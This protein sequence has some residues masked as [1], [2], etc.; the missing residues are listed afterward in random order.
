MNPNAKRLRIQRA[1]ADADLAAAMA[2]GYPPAIAAAETYQQ[3][4]IGLQMAFAAEQRA[5]FVQAGFEREHS[6][7]RFQSTR[8]TSGIFE[9]E[10][11]SGNETL[12]MRPDPPHSPS[13]DYLPEETFTESQSQTYS[14]KLDLFQRLPSWLHSYAKDKQRWSVQKCAATLKNK[15]D[16]WKPVFKKVKP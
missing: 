7:A 4:V 12:A 10:S 8:G 6:R 16:N 3:M 15:E 14:Y 11:S 5:V 2:S 13:P 1:H 9:P